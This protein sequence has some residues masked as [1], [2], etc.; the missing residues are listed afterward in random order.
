MN[1]NGYG[2]EAEWDGRQLVARG[3]NKATRVALRGAEHDQGDLVVP[4]AELASVE[5]RE[6]GKLTNGRLTVHTTGGASYR[7]NFL[8]KHAEG[9]RQLHTELAQHCG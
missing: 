6:A 5:L 1:V 9:F 2:V 7:L 3:T 4:A 8:R